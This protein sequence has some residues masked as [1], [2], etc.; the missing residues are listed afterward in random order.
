MPPLFASIMYKEKEKLRTGQWKG[1]VHRMDT[2]QEEET[3]LLGTGT[4]APIYS[5]SSNQCSG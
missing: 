4:Q 1:K 2:Y 3:G 5:E